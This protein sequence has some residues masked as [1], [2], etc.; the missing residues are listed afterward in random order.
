MT[1]IDA[2]EVEPNAELAA[3]VCIVGAGAAGLTLAGALDGTSLSVCVIESGGM[4]PDPD[5]QALYDLDVRGYPVRENFMSRARYYGGSC[6][7][8]AGRSMRFTAQD[9]APRAWVPH[10]GW[11]LEYGELA[12]Y[13]PAAARVLGL[14]GDELFDASRHASQLTD[15]ERRLY[16]ADRLVPAVSLWARRPKR[17][18]AGYRATLRRSRNIRLIL[19]GNVVNVRLHA[20]GTRVESVDVAT[21]GGRRFRVRANVVVLACGGLE[22]ARLLLA[23]R[24]QHAAGIGNAHD[25]VGRYFM[26]HPRGV[27]GRVHLR[28][29]ARLSL[30][31]G[32]PRAE[33]KVQFGVGL[34]PALQ[35][36]E[37][38]LDHYATVEVEH[39]EYTARQYQSFIRTM[40]V[41]LRRGYAGSRWDVG[42]RAKLSDISGLMYLLT[43]K[44]LMPH[45]LYR[46]YW[47]ARRMV[48]RRRAGGGRRVVVYFCEQPPDPASRVT[49]TAERDALGLPRLALDWRLPPSVHESVCRLQSL[50]KAQLERAGVGTLEEGDGEVRFTDASHH[51]GTTRMSTTP[52]TGV[53]DTHGMV[54]GVHGLYVAGSS[55]FPAASHK[56]P[57]LTI[58]A[59]SLRMAEHLQRVEA[60]A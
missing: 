3:D 2:T 12:A 26:D 56:N 37:A 51:M 21:L 13:Y 40:K 41:L 31:D 52:R 48:G 17:F 33:G 29:G 46:A 58:V 30:L 9:F 42:R 49:L 55:V 19:R 27:Y 45:A 25:V 57:T 22:N 8:W 54:H 50:L 6:N 15:Q 35:E 34:S 43:P 32:W 20:D 23:S 7:I 44:E 5:T 39:S 4:E 53:V 11:P 16:D 60:R 38:L 14:P 18:G 10:S 47:R 36:R 1:I 24:E 59:L 28:E